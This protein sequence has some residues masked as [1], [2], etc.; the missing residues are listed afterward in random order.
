MLKITD[1]T[2]KADA[3]ETLNTL[4]SE[5]DAQASYSAKVTAADKAWKAKRSTKVKSDAIDEVR[6]TL[7]S[8]CVGPVRCAYC[9][10]SLA[11]EIEHIRPKAFFP[12]LT[13][14]WANYLFACG[15][16]NGP[17][18]SR[19]G[20]INGDV[21][22]EF[23]RKRGDDVSPPQ[24]GPSALIDPRMEDPL[25][26]FELDLGGE[27]PDGSD[28]PATFMFLSNELTS[29]GNQARA[30]FSIDVLGLN[31][32]VMRVARQNAFTGFR[33]RLREYAEEKEQGAAPE[34]LIYLRDNILAT[35]HLTVFAEMRRQQNFLPSIRALFERA[36]EATLWPLIS[37]E[38]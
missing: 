30:T 26:F 22:D 16:C 9:E 28:V 35:P 8:M 38:A 19:Y 31:R 1:R 5:I 13:F 25:D 11:D 18:R 21:V 33:A 10:D 6:K 2:L 12:D 7:A 23:I 20:V 15:P 24:A 29:L 3:Q 36:P 32:E 14:R 17:K 27:A 34:R 37:A 4:Q